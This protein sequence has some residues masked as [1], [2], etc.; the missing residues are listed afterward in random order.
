MPAAAGFRTLIFHDVGPLD[1]GAFEDLIGFL[2]D[3]KA[4]ISPDQAAAWLA[5]QMPPDIDRQ[6]GPQP[7]LISFDDGF[8]GNYD[9]AANVLAAH[10]IEAIFFVCPG[11][12]DLR[13]E[14]QMEAVR[15]NVLTGSSEQR[16]DDQR[17]RLMSWQ[18]INDL[19]SAGHTIGA[20]G[21]THLSLAK[22]S[23]DA[24]RNEITTSGDII[25]DH[26][27]IPVEWYAY[28]FGG[29]GNISSSAFQIIKKRFPYCRAGIRG[30]NTMQTSPHA[31]FGDHLELS[32]PA[33]YQH[34]TI[35]GFLDPLYV[36]KRR[37]LR[38]MLNGKDRA[39]RSN[40]V[41]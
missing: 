33:A 27:S 15:A 17:C 30:L 2:M 25:E 26:I 36:F 39:A 14:A 32:A 13:P 19:S 21:M 34:L 41:A 16:L 1:R 10:A 7:C 11:L 28:A 24:L 12:V 8:I 20:H 38:S 4:V 35:D 29:I 9:L 5:G 18:Q 3:R 22:L 23:D 40:S 31:I 37:R 6:A